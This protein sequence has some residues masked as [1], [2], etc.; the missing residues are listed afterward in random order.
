MRILIFILILFSSIK[1]SSQELKVSLDKNPALTNEIIQLQFSINAKGNDFIP[2][3]LSNFHILNG[4]SQGFSQ[5][6]SNINGK[7]T[8]EIK[9]TISYNIQAKKDG[10]Y[11]IGPASV[12][13]NNKT[14]KSKSVEI[15]IEKSTIKENKIINNEKHVFIKLQINKSEI[16][17]G[18]Q[19]SAISRIYIKNGVNLQNTEISPIKYDGF[20]EEE[21]EI[22]TNKKEREIINGIAYDVI[23]FR[24]SV[25]TA[26]KSGDI[27]IPASEMEVSI[28]VRGKLIGYDFFNRPQYQTILKSESI[29]SRP[30]KIKVKE[31][32]RPKPKHF[33][34]TVSEKFTINSE[35]DKTNLTTSEAISF[36][37]T[38]R[39]EG[40][41]N[42]LDPF[43]IEF[44]SSFEV[45]EPIITDK[46]YVGNNNTGGTKTFEYILIPRKKG[47]F[48]IPEIKFSYFN[49]K[50]EKYIELNTKEHLISVK[51]DAETDQKVEEGIGGD[52][53]EEEYT[54][55]DTTQNDIENL[56]SLENSKNSSITKKQFF[57]EWYSIALWIIFIVI[58]IS[59]L[60]YFSLS[61]R[62][63]NKKE[64]R[65]KKSNKIAIKR[66]K[67]ASFCL[68]NGNF[69]QFFEEIEKSL[70]GYFADKFEVNSSELSKETIDLYFNKRNVKTET[71]N[72]FI[73]LLNICEFAR[74]S[75]SKDRNQQMEKILENAKE[76]IIEVESDMK[77]KAYKDNT[78]SND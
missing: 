40:N 6:Y 35:I 20:W 78:E 38:L 18:E 10:R 26:Q 57:S 4:P 64:T 36:K 43:K 1:S 41:I 48:T 28:A 8:E 59:Y 61:K 30:R 23:K 65:R 24:H 44:P 31:L 51:K 60:V 16:F 27:I 5:S 66:L 75:P 56:D 12:K 54:S 7:T 11:I 39:G 15:V 49:P 3:S 52:T 13:V 45:F 50:T 47:D 9:T 14:I 70:W 33:Y 74:Y 32:P 62:R 71:K 17:I 2:P 46:T 34:G 53:L 63:E 25:L 37:L 72:N 19:I 58:I 77:K 29:N 22:K 42:M 67:N 55:S 73:S 76:I 68:K 21:I 69:N